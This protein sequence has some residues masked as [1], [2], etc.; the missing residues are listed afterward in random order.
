MKLPLSVELFLGVTH[1]LEAFIFLELEMIICLEKGDCLSYRHNIRSCLLSVL[2]S[3]ITFNLQLEN[4]QSI[5]LK[6][7]GF[8]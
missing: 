6:C 8:S 4:P 5:I 3:F 2:S 7:N 1:V